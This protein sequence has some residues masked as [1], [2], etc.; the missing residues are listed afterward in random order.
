MKDLLSELISPGC[1]KLCKKRGTIACKYNSLVHRTRARS[2]G[3]TNTGRPLKAWGSAPQ[4]DLPK[5]N[6]RLAVCER[7]FALPFEGWSVRSLQK[8]GLGASLLTMAAYGGFLKPGRFKKWVAC[9][10][11]SKTMRKVVPNIWTT[12]TPYV[13]IVMTFPLPTFVWWC[14]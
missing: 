10:F 8:G 6:A 5:F 2:L 9:K 14:F 11:D 13:T 1:Y 12:I 3:A 7:G 4:G